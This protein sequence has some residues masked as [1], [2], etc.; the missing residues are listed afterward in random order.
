MVR[1]HHQLNG[2]ESEQTPGESEGQESLMF[3]S[4]W[5]CK[6]VDMTE[7][8]KQHTHTHTLE[9]QFKYF[10]EF[11]KLAVILAGYPLWG[12]PTWCSGK[13]PTCPCRRH[14]RHGFNPWVR[15]ITWSRKWQ[16]TQC[17][18]LEKPMGRD[19]WSMGSQRVR[20]L[21]VTEQ[22]LPSLNGSLPLT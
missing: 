6:G 14:K 20:H 3:Y 15:K 13:E 12:L 17:K 21:Q 10:S 22:A 7:T 16:P 4:P 8:E 18:S 9:L 19:R 2:Y 11:L 5:G 1:Q